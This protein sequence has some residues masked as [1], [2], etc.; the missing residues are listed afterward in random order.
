MD[1]LAGFLDFISSY[2]KMKNTSD[3]IGMKD[4]R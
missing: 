1:P 3:F 2:T 4:E